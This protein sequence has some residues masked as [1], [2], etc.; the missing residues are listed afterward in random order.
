MKKSRLE[1][2]CTLANAYVGG[3]PHTTTLV[4]EVLREMLVALRNSLGNEASAIENHQRDLDLCQYTPWGMV[5][6]GEWAMEMKEQI[7]KMDNR[8]DALG[9][10]ILMLSSFSGKG[11]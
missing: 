10:T 6:D 3:E 8:L 2:I 11:R 9:Q 5:I 1:Q 4:K 7:E